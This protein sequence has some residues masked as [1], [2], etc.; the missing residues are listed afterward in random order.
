VECGKIRARRGSSIEYLLRSAQVPAGTDWRFPERDLHF[1]G[2]GRLLSDLAL[3]PAQL[4][5]LRPDVEVHGAGIGF[6]TAGSAFLHNLHRLDEFSLTRPDLI[7]RSAA[8]L[9]RRQD[10]PDL[11]PVPADTGGLQFVRPELEAQ[12]RPSLAA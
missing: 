3:G 10:R 8:Y 7:D 6:D 4:Q 9:S 11:C 2:I 1:D 5:A 12:A